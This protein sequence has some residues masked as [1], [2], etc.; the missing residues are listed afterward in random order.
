M[1]LPALLQLIN[2]TSTAKYRH[3]NYIKLTLRVNVVCVSVN[4]CACVSLNACHCECMCVYECVSVC[5][6]VES[7]YT[8][9]DVCVYVC[10]CVLVCVCVCE[11]AN[12]VFS[13]ENKVYVLSSSGF[14]AK[15]S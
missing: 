3:A 13:L 2:T 10:A 11:H 8:C 9:M 1:S 4:A 14:N 7:V 6:C 12:N 15:V 5:I